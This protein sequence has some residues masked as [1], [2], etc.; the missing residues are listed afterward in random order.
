MYTKCPTGVQ[1]PKDWY[2]YET[3]QQTQ[4]FMLPKHNKKIHHILDTCESKSHAKHN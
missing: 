4:H 3:Q 2:N 1:I